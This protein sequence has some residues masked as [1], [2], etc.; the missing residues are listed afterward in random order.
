MNK[1]SRK[2]KGFR[3]FYFKTW[4]PHGDSN[5]GLIRERDLS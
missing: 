2:R 3:D 1:K 4:Y 5:P